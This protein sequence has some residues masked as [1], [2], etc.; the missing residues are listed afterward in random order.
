MNLFVVLILVFIL[1]PTTGSADEF[2]D[3]VNETIDEIVKDE[4][5]SEEIID[6]NNLY[7]RTIKG[8]LPFSKKRGN[9]KLGVY[10]TLFGYNP[11]LNIS[12]THYVPG[13]T[14]YENDLI[15]KYGAYPRESGVVI[16]NCKVIDKK[17]IVE[18]DKVSIRMTLK[19]YGH[20][21]V[22]V[23][24]TVHTLLGSF[25]FTYWKKVNYTFTETLTDSVEKP[26][27]FSNTVNVTMIEYQNVMEIS[28]NGTDIGSIVIETIGPASIF[29][30]T[31]VSGN[32]SFTL[33]DTF[34]AKKDER[35]MVYGDAFDVPP[36][37]N[38]SSTLITYSGGIFYVPKEVIVE[39]IV[40]RSPD[41]T[42]KEMSIN[43]I[44]VFSNNTPSGWRIVI[45]I[46]I[47]MRIFYFLFKKLMMW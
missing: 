18:D 20:K 16:D 5:T 12:G 1:G 3:Q 10:L 29:N 28:V 6:A 25:T 42:P 39:D 41:G 47:V 9:G 7:L 44:Q 13:N 27:R 23:T 21:W 36:V 32:I 17:V 24:R 26:D 43:R 31:N 11:R 35:G 40:V 2:D 30:M 38:Y 4:V 14:D 15:F 45:M 8:P 22:K 19:G 46:L 37:T 34:L 33:T